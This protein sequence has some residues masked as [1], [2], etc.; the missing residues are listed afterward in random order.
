MKKSVVIGCGIMLAALLVGCG[1]SGP[2]ATMKEMINLMNEQAA[3]MEGKADKSKID[4]LEAKGKELKKKFDSFTKEQQE[5]AKEKY[6]DEALKATQRIM[7]AA[8][9]GDIFE[10]FKGI[11]MPKIP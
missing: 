4:A 9:L 5:A 8:G 10:K 2:D 7:K 3:L 6:K 1:S 11:K